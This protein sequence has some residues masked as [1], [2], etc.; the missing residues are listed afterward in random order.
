MAVE[1]NRDIVVFGASAGGFEAMRRILAALPRGL[2][3]TF[4]LAQHLSPHL[5]SNLPDLLS[6][7]SPYAAHYPVDG[8]RTRRGLLYVAPPDNQMLVHEGQ[9][10]VN[11]GPRENGHRP[12]VDTLFR[13]A[14]RAYASRV[15]GVV[16]TGYL[17]CGT[18]GLLS[19][20]AR[21]GLALVQDPNSAVAGEMPSSA[22]AHVDVDH[23]AQVDEI[24]PLLAQL[25]G[26]PAPPQPEQVSRF[27]RQLEGDELGAQATVVCPAC[28]GMVTE[29][30]D[31]QFTQLRCHVGHAFA[32]QGALQQQNEEAERALWEAVRA[33]E[34]GAALASRLVRGATGQLHTRFAERERQ[35]LRHADVIRRILLGT[36]TSAPALPTD[37]TAD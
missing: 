17:D 36:E 16:L 20:K 19:I 23:V 28:R 14:S 24:A 8:E 32:P 7:G 21:G 2:P 33:L 35:L 6:K 30:S 27:V 37:P 10:R 34:E 31:G 22:I 13:S 18:A 12:S 3:A 4:F 25:I 5:Q 9:V 26:T 15:I 11:R 29:A 1:Q